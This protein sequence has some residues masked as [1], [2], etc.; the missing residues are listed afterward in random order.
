MLPAKCGCL[1][2]EKKEND[3]TCN[4]SVRTRVM[5]TEGLPGM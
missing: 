4:E 5:R 3:T 1:L 2:P